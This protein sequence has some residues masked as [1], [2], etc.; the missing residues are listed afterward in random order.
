MDYS[1]YLRNKQEAANV[2]IARNKSV[3]SSFLTMQKQ[4]KAAYSGSAIK[5]TPTYFKGNPTLN[6]I[7]YDVGSCPKNHAYTQGYSESNP[8]AQHSRQTDIKAGGVLCCGPDYATAPIGMMLK[9]PTE[10]STILSSNNN[11]IVPS[12]AKIPVETKPHGLGSMPGQWRSYGYGQNHYFP[13]P[14]KN[15]G[16]DCCDVNKYPYGSG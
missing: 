11:I 5:N 1:Q 14:D 10:V 6:P 7:L 16:S 13:K 12:N 8:V 15:S 4:Q 2:Y 9:N 3:D